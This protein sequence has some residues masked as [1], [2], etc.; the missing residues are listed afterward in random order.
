MSC[1][2]LSAAIAA[3]NKT[4]P[5]SHRAWSQESKKKQNKQVNIYIQVMI[6]AVREKETGE[7]RQSGEEWWTKILLEKLTW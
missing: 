3:V 7:S 1:T 2:V 5:C 6:G 4:N